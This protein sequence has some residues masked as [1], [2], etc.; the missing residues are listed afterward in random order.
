LR[1]LG[2]ADYRP[3]DLDHIG[4]W[5]ALARSCGWW[6]A[7]EELCVVVERPAAARTESYPGTWH[8][9]VRLKPD[10]LRYRDG[11]QPLLT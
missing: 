11:W 5:A 10:G 4:C 2:L 7:S 9:E 3:D 8:D 6:W 1:R